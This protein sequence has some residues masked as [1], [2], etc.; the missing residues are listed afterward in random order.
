MSVSVLS[1]LNKQALNSANAHKHDLHADIMCLSNQAAF[2]GKFFSRSD[3]HNSALLTP[4]KDRIVPL[5]ERHV[6]CSYSRC[7]IL[8]ARIYN[9]VLCCLDF[10]PKPNTVV[11]TAFMTILFYFYDPSWFP[12]I[13]YN[14]LKNIVQT[15]P[16]ELLRLKKPP[17]TVNLTD[18]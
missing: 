5:T 9:A 17:K 3:L 16:V 1:R 7:C 11:K 6:C 18:L 12:Y 15:I 14:I 10:V 13:I 8:S 2:P 4:P